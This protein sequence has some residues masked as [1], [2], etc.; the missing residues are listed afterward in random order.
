MIIIGILIN[1]RA[2]AFAEQIEDNK[3]NT[4]LNINNQ[5]EYYEEIDKYIEEDTGMTIEESL[6]DQLEYYK[7]LID[8]HKDNTQ[9]EHLIQTTR[10]L[11]NYH[12]KL[13]VLKD[14][15]GI[16]LYADGSEYTPY[17]ACVMAAIG[18]FNASNYK[19]SAELLTH[20]W[21]INF[22]PGVYVPVNGMKV[23]S[24]QVTYDILNQDK[25]TG[26]MSY[27]VEWPLVFN[28]SSRN[29]EDLGYALK[30]FSYSR[31]SYET[32]Q[33]TITDEYNFDN[34]VDYEPVLAAL[35]NVFDDAIRIGV[36]RAYDIRIDVDLSEPLR[37]EIESVDLID[38]SVSYSVKVHNYSD[39]DIEFYYNEK[40]CNGAD[41]ENW[42]GLSDIVID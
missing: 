30:D 15:K 38:N 12:E 42:T 27:G 20:S 7:N 35:V 19:L 25:L 6:Y 3:S 23:L 2:N 31:E 37:L 14:N 39:S 33:I 32:K 26:R 41:A 5:P 28:G 11:I 40:M 4:L 36:L 22:T 18:W 24:S 9:I 21:S 1:P 29:E 8:K 34:T 10:E 17:T 16:S 13:S